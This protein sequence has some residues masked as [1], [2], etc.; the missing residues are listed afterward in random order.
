[1]PR[2]G[3]NVLSQFLRTKCDKQLRLSLY[4]PNELLAMGWPV[5]LT[6]RPTVQILRD[7][8]IDWEQAKMADLESA[9]RTHL[10]ASKLNGKFKEIELQPVLQQTLTSPTFILQPSFEHLNLKSAFLQ[11]IGVDAALIQQ[12]PAF[13][14][15]RPDII[16]VQTRTDDEVEILPNGETYAIQPADQRKALAICDIKHAGEAN[17]RL[18]RRLGGKRPGQVDS[19]YCA[20]RE[21][22]P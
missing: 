17:S 11:S 8:G 7:V 13:G 9:F 12:V 16:C 1:M 14:A 5:P 3:K 18:C 4:A 22:A 6:A 15:F 21:A 10:R 20:E 2:F 19:S